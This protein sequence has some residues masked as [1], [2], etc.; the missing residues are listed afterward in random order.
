[1]NVKLVAFIKLGKLT[2]AHHYLETSDV[3]N[4]IVNIAHT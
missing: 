2:V 4:S 1:M 3:L